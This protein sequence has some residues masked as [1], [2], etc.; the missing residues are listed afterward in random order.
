MPTLRHVAAVAILALIG[1]NAAL[2]QSAPLSPPPAATSPGPSQTLSID[3]PIETLVATPTA[4]AALDA[5]IPGLTTHPMYDKFKHESLRGVA[6]KFGGAITDKDLA[7]LQA[8]LA[9][10]PQ[11]SASR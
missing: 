1:G 6:P 10:L 4:K 5:D 9:A 3:T 8:D 7:K 11:S 2:A